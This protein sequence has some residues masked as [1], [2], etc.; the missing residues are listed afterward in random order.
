[1]DAR[2]PNL[3][4]PRRAPRGA[5]AAGAA[6]IATL[7]G[8]SCIPQPTAG[9]DPDDGRIPI[10]GTGE[11]LPAELREA[12]W[13]LRNRVQILEQT[14]ERRAALANAPNRERIDGILADMQATVAPLR[15]HAQELGRPILEHGLPELD[16]A[17]ERARAD[18][19]RTPPRF[20]G[21]DAVA[22]AC[23][24]CHREQP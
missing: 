2:R 5:V 6:L 7:L 13:D 16:A 3:A 10:D 24:D 22:D 19:A 20:A 12:M 9:R 4:R 17:L 15:G 14:L 18:L 21:A 11:P 23:L 1:M 8:A